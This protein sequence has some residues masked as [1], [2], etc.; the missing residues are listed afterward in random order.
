MAKL[1]A[2]LRAGSITGNSVSLSVL[3]EKDA[4]VTGG[5]ASLTL[6]DEQTAKFFEQGKTYKIQIE[7]D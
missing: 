5:S 6:K 4:K 7:K 2:K 1:E 3:S